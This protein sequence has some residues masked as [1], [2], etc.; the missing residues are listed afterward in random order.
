MIV[1]VADVMI[2]EAVAVVVMIVVAA[3]AA[4]LVAAEDANKIK[5]SPQSGMAQ[6]ALIK[7]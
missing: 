3:A 7:G 2:A 6:K 5:M 4:V 1:V